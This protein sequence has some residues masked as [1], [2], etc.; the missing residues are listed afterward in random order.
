[1]SDKPIPP[2]PRLVCGSAATGVRIRSV[3]DRLQKLGRIVV[4][5]SGLLAAGC[6]GPAPA[7]TTA[8]GPAGTASDNAAPLRLAGT[9]EATRSQSVLVPRLAGQVAP[10]LVITY[11]VRPG[12]RVNPGDLIVEFDRQEQMRAATDRR[13]ELVDLDGQIQKKRSEHAIARAKDE[14]ELA[15]AERN[16]ERA[17]LEARKN[18]LVPKIEA[19]KNTLAVEQSTARFA[20]L[21]ET[22]ELKR[23]A[24]EAEIK[25]LEIQRAR[26][27][28]ALKYS[29]ANALLMTVNAPFAGFVVVKQVW[30]G[31]TQAEVQEGEEVRPGT[32]IIDIVDPAAM[33]VRARIAQ[34]DVNV[35]V[36][37]QPA[38]IRL[39][40]YPE[41][42]FDGRV[43]TVAPLGVQSGLT[44]KVRAFTAIVSINGMHPQLMPDLSASVEV[45]PAASAAPLTTASAAPA[46]PG[47]Q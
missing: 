41:L 5:C 32:P 19:E 18:E 20:Q 38:K 3:F 27:E 46:R 37:G 43:E 12:A 10:T 7:T 30:K 26:S 22:F 42:L 21:K 24:A 1:M 6:R 9:V 44:P 13:A 14:T 31:N 17:L 8:G 29:E 23:R 25:I 16:V 35:V 28:R 40:A 4:T 45:V 47:G 15:E 34:S 11:L 2:S 33:Q 39:D 36:P